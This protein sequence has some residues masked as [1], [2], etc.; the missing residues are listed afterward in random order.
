VDEGYSTSIL[1]SPTW[2]ALGSLELV[3]ASHELLDY[4]RHPSEYLGILP[5]FPISL[6]GNIFLVDVIV[7]QGLLDFNMLLGRDYVYA[8]NIVVST[9]FWVICISLTME[10]LSLSTSRHMLITILIQC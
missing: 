8:M 10:V 5:Q 7:V 3:F 1:H 9:L 4:D 6:G 2:K